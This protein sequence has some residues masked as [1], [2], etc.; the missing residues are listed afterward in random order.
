[1]ILLKELAENSQLKAVKTKNPMFFVETFILL[2]EFPIISIY[3]DVKLNKDS[4][5]RF[6][7]KFEKTLFVKEKLPE[8]P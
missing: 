5:R 3:I 1:L 8:V 7:V 6:P 2:K 4:K